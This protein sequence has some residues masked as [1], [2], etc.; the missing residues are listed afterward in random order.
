[1]RR[2]YRIGTIIRVVF[3]IM[4]ASAG[5]SASIVFS[6][7]YHNENAAAWSGVSAAFAIFFLY[8]V[9]SVHRDIQRKIPPSRFILYMF[10]GAVGAIMGLAV[11]IAYL[12]IGATRKESGIVLIQ[13][14]FTN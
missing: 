7:K 4:G 10:V 6:K 5:I 13:F 12:V 1:M 2:K 8:M 14:I 9:F 11:F 3:A